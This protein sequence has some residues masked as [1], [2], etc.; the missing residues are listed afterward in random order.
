MD[1]RSDRGTLQGEC[2]SL[3]APWT[4]P[5][6]KL[7]YSIARPEE[8]ELGFRGGGVHYGIQKHTMETIRASVANYSEPYISNFDEPL[9]PRQPGSPV[10][11]G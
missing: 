10:R 3:C 1:I 2:K 7:A 11:A 9:R 4:T 6:S 8:I 5:L